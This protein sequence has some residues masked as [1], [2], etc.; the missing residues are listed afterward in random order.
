MLKMITQPSIF[1]LFFILIAQIHAQSN[2]ETT[3]L[4]FDQDPDLKYATFG[5][6]AID[7][8]RNRVVA[9]RNP[10]KALAP[11]SSL[12]VVTTGVALA[13]LGADYQFET[14]LQYDGS[15]QNGVLSGNLYIKGTGDPT[16]G[17]P[18]MKDVPSTEA[19]MNSFVE[20]VRKQGIKKINGAV[21]GDASFFDPQSITPTWQWG[22][23]GNH[24]GTGVY[25]LNIH[26]NLYYIVF[27]QS[28]KFGAKPKIKHF[29][30][31][32]PN[33]KMENLVTNAGR[34]TGDNAYVYVAPYGENAYVEGTIPVGSSE[35]EV[36]GAVPNPPLLAA[37]LLKN[38]L[39]E[40]G[41]QVS[42]GATTQR[43]LKA[44]AERNTFYTHLSPKLVDIV[45]H[46]NEESRNMYCEALIKAIGLKRL[47]KATLVDGLAAVTEFWR[48]R[49]IDTRSFFIKDGSGLSA[50]NAVTAKTMAQIMRKMHIDKV[51]FHD[52]YNQLAVVG[53]TGTTQRLCLG[54]SAVGN[55]HAKSGS[56][57][58]IRSYT[59]YATTKKGNL[60]SFSMIINNYSCSGYVMRKKFEKL[61]IA[62]AELNE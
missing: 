37:N 46:T 48:S 26:D 45:K 22:D 50:R 23:I 15:L 5:F 7:I 55:I 24:Y 53:K 31:S 57:N 27:Q 58:R 36:K 42:K 9:Q 43:I 19:L 38:A 12:K 47:Q 51:N 17:S 44:R 60:L 29:R 52:F 54:T 14:Y 16:L 33:L 30:P 59:G 11:A 8:N 61:M 18:F 32:V 49:G 6:C 25:G 10:N 20:V 56:M 3:L 4:Q 2:L 28:S 40:Q 39:V 62:M 41:I 21:V 13:T 34:R 1:F 35:F